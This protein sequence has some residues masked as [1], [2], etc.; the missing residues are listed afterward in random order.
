MIHKPGHFFIILK[1]LC[2]SREVEKGRFPMEKT[3]KRSN[4]KIIIAVIALC[5]VVAATL[6]AYLLLIPRGVE[7]EK[8]IHI[9]V[10]ADGT[11]FTQTIHTNA[12]YLRQALDEV[13]LIDGEDSAFGLWVTT[14]NGRTADDN[15]QEWWALYANGEFA[16]L[17][18]DDM[19]IEDGD[20]F[21][22]RLTV[23][24]DDMDW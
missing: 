7:G 11:T 9:E 5:L 8:T 20:R 14:V 15:A 2:R 13:N 21:E 4:K 1:Y 19:P 6:T 3:Q 24:F 17:G 18:V 10:I 23:G 22:Y 16:M 12:A